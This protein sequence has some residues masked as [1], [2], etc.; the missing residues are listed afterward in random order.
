M[1]RRSPD[2]SERLRTGWA[3]PAVLIT[4]LCLFAHTLTTHTFLCDDDI[5]H[6]AQLSHAKH[7]PKI[8][9]PDCFCPMWR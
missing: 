3:V 1:M 8:F 9:H 6:L 4:G 5:P 7:L 2:T